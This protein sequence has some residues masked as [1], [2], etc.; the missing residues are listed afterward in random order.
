MAIAIYHQ[1]EA[2]IARIGRQLALA[3]KED[4]QANEADKQEAE[5]QAAKAKET[6]ERLWK[7]IEKHIPTK[8]RSEEEEYNWLVAAWYR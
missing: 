2:E 5:K 4:P 7:D 1:R 6:K 3:I 8:A